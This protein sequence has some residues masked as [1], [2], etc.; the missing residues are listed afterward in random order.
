MRS[1]A[2]AALGALASLALA[3]AAGASG[4]ELVPLV[5][6]AGPFAGVGAAELG[7]AGAFAFRALP[8]GITTRWGVYAGG[9]AAP[10]EL[11]FEDWSAAFGIG[12][13]AT[14]RPGIDAEGRV[15]YSTRTSNQGSQSG[16]IH[17]SDQQDPLAEAT[18]ATLVL[19]PVAG[20][21]SLAFL[22][23]DATLADPEE[24]HDVVYRRAPGGPA[25]EVARGAPGAFGPL[26]YAGGNEV[27]FRREDAADAFRIQIADGATVRTVV[28]QVGPFACGG[29]SGCFSPQVSIDPAGTV[30]FR[31]LFDGGAEAGIFTRSADGAIASWADT[32][33]PFAQVGLPTLGSG[34]LADGS[35]RIAFVGSRDDDP[36]RYGIYVGPD[37]VA[38]LVLEEGDPLLGSVVEELALEDFTSGGLL[39]FVA[40]LADGRQV[41]LR[42]QPVPEPAG[43]AAA[44]VGLVAVLALRGR[45]AAKAAAPV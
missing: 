3:P 23:R 35:G 30:G 37:P 4:W 44:L 43:A 31:A 22:A 40:R 7:E 9:G 24:D 36:L 15:Y 11:L 45:R 25:V 1:F 41:L 32:R 33:G 28:W 26:A 13:S 6:T 16:A 27:A 38:D 18:G 10:P 34:P 17:V 42:A 39:A 5:D 20:E 14:G 29:P 12:G 19:G 21:G 2:A 8:D